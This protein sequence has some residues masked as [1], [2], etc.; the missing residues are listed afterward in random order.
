MAVELK[1]AHARHELFLPFTLTIVTDSDDG[2]WKFF[3]AGL[4]VIAT[5][6]KIFY[7]QARNFMRENADEYA[8]EV[9]HLIF[10]QDRRISEHQHPEML[11]VDLT[12]EVHLRVGDAIGI[13]Y[14][15]KLRE[16]GLAYA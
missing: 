12:E 11:P 5:K 8:N 15:R 3:F 13:A 6:V 9:S 2:V 14:R 4:P 1:P 10:E 16:I 7:V